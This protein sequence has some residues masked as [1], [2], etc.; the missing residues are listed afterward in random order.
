[1]QVSKTWSLK[2]QKSF[3]SQMDSK[4]ATALSSPIIGTQNTILNTF[5][6]AMLGTFQTC[7]QSRRCS[8]GQQ[9][10]ERKNAEL[11][12]NAIQILNSLLKYLEKEY[13]QRFILL[14]SGTNCATAIFVA[15]WILQPPPILLLLGQDHN[16]SQQKILPSPPSSCLSMTSNWRETCADQRTTT[17][18]A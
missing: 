3:Y 17:R 1:M 13:R 15:S 18:F 14:Y 7:D 6:R 16:L 10:A 11:H 12:F 4:R 2:S 5:A 9:T 8:I